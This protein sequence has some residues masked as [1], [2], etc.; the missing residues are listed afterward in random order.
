[1]CFSAL[2]YQEHRRFERDYGATIDMRTYIRLFWDWSKGS[3][4]KV[5]K[6]MQDAF[7]QPR[8]DEEREIH[9]L[10][11]QRNEA[12]ALRIQEELF[13]QK[14]RLVA[15]E[16]KLATKET[17]AA[18]NDQRIATDKIDKARLRLEDLNRTES[19]PRDSRIFPGWYS[20]VLIEENGQRLVRPMRYQCRIA[21]MPAS[22]DKTKT[23]QVSGTYNA[24]RDNLTR[25]WRNQFGITHGVIV[26]SRF[27]EN[28]EKDGKNQVLEFVPRTGEDMLVACLWSR[29]TDPTGKDDDLYSF[30]AITDEPE[31]E[32]AAAGHDRTIINIKP[33]NL[34]A[35]LRGG[36]TAAMQAIFDDKRH[37]YYEHRMAA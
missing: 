10:I 32:V 19:K 7:A 16:R 25:Y 3:P 35:W 20:A 26:A 17:K 14:Q 34:D 29:W 36:D 9:G 15:A 30:A 23:G 13:A 2:A 11:R 24:R 33:E 12:E 5:P 1:M 31:P 6:A 22:S 18:L 4:Y 8:N 21:G 37:P 28:V 27:Y